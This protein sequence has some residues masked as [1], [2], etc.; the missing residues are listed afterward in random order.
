MK[1]VLDASIALAWL[2]EREQAAEIKRAEKAL[3][4]LS[5]AETLVPSLWHTEVVN[6]LLT[7]ERRKVVTEARVID[8]LNRLTGLP[9]VTDDSL[10]A[11]HRDTVMALAREYKLTA[12]DATYLELALREDAVLATFDMKLA[13]AMQ[14]AGGKLFK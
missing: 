12:Y 3:L 7:G 14:Q 1:I 11:S 4:A 6:A 10:P 8:Y 5:E 2:F 13:A 9:I